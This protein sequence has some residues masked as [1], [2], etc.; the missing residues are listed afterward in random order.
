MS[1]TDDVK[2]WT[3]LIEQGIRYKKNFGNCDKWDTYRRYY[4]G[5]FPG[6]SPQ[7][8]VLPYN[9]V[10][11]MARTLV[12]NLYFRNPYITV[13][14]RYKPGFEIHAKIMEAV[15]NWLIQEMG[16]KE[17]IKT[18]IL[19]AFFTSK[20]IL[21]VGYDSQYGF[22]PSDTVSM[23]GVTDATLT[24]FNKKGEHLEY[25]VNIKPGMPWVVRVVPDDIVVP[26]GVRTLEECEWI[27]HRVYRPL[28][29][30][31][32]DPKYKN[33][34]ELK[35]SHLEQLYKE[36]NRKDFYNELTKEADWVE[37]WEIRDYKRREVSAVVFGYPDFIRP[38]EED[39]LQIEGLPFGDITFNEDPEW[40][41]GT[42][43]VGIIEPQQLEINEARTQAMAH[44]RIALM[45]F[46]V[47]GT[48][49]EDT[50]IAKMLSENV[51]PVVKLKGTPGQE[52]SI[53]QPH[54][55]PDLI[56]W[57]EQIRQDIRELMGMGRQQ[58]GESERSSRKTAYE[59]SVVQQA[60]ELRLDERRDMVADTLAN[61]M[62]KVNQIIFDRWDTSHVVQ[63]VGVD[64]SKYWVE[65]TRDAIVGE[66]N[67][68]IDVESMT[69]VTKAL[70]KKDIVELIG[71]LAKHPR[72]NIDYLLRALL[73]EY[74]W[75]DAMAVLPEAPETQQGP[76][77]ANQFM[78]QQQGLMKNP[79]QLGARQ[80]GNMQQIQGA[81]G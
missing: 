36:N 6:V 50:E 37:I 53:L 44:R 80:R 30:V 16:V 45:K 8:G 41:W 14:P 61:V 77:G 2:R 72:A 34:G 4:R 35:G 27:A 38:P 26:F 22:S 58:M 1:Q 21:K 76:M 46:L 63:V 5:Q 74:E 25:N 68:K 24:G 54:I 55:P 69:P 32:K 62:R 56:G 66:Y 39:V 13:T 79:A 19:D 73:R 18:A 59:V 75:I 65:Y 71:A 9:L 29:D 67:L 20:G 47:N 23:G 42:P 49:I 70:K 31:K 52:V 7:K 78:A 51:G 10:F 57:V 12:P 43:D 33:V 40:Y 81:M 11:A 64:G 17:V 3:E 60:L 28:E 15:D 48:L